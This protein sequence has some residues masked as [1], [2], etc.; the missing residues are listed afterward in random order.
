MFKVQL[1]TYIREYKTNTLASMCWKLTYSLYRV[2]LYNVEVV[3][4]MLWPHQSLASSSPWTPKCQHSFRTIYMTSSFNC[5]L[6]M[7]SLLGMLFL[8]PGLPCSFLK[9][10]IPSILATHLDGKMHSWEGFAHTS[11]F[12]LASV[13]LAC[14]PSYYHIS[15]GF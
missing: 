4:Q 6:S 5:P 11:T 14:L 3:T 10:C 13:S 7:C 12:F 1:S 2:Y 15:P 8:N 9:G